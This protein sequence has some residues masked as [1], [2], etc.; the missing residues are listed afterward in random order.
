MAR[1]D[2]DNEEALMEGQDNI[3]DTQDDPGLT[4]THNSGVDQDNF[5]YE[6]PLLTELLDK[7]WDEEL[8]VQNRD[9]AN[10]NDEEEEPISISNRFQS[11][12]GMNEDSLFLNRD[13]IDNSNQATKP[14]RL[15]T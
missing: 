11:F 13:R 3:I 2:M 8:A 9:K 7:N 15:S 14:K 6:D 4:E 12:A 5:N 10:D 1:E